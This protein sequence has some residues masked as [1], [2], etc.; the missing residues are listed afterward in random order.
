[1]GFLA[2]ELDM[3]IEDDSEILEQVFGL[4]LRYICKCDKYTTF[5]KSVKKLIDFN[6]YDFSENDFRIKVRENGY[7]LTGIKY[8]ALAYAK[9]KNCPV[10]AEKLYPQYD[11]YRCDA[12]AIKNIYEQKGFKRNLLKD[13]TFDTSKAAISPEALEDAVDL[14]MEMLPMVT[15]FSKLMTNK[16]RFI[17]NSNNYSKDEFE[18]EFIAQALRSYYYT[19]PTDKTGLELE[20]S[21]RSA[22]KN[23]Q[24]NIIHANTTQ[25][26][27][28]MVNAGKD[29]HGNDKFV[30]N[31]VSQSQ[32]NSFSEEGEEIEFDGMLN[33]TAQQKAEN[34]FFFMS[35]DR[36][37]LKNL[38]SRKIP[39]RQQAELLAIF[40]G[41]PNENFEKYLRDR[42]VLRSDTKTFTDFIDEKPRE[43][44]L[45]E[46]SNYMQISDN[47]V[48]KHLRAIGRQLALT[49][50]GEKNV[51]TTN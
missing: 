35:V 10:R 16:L 51:G 15:K 45:S 22:M 37:I 34:D 3:D 27:Q 26:R 7:L 48:R 18:S 6:Q 46:I 31:L 2:L 40:T 25:S 50:N 12:K 5:T 4:C 32:M 17:V 8:Y 43:V 14:F 36:L 39:K 44:Y 11:I 24:T 49:V 21:L 42:N 29:E 19:I 23:H 30:M 38:K 41:R 28:R 13:T 9:G 33:E 47:T 20:N 1:M